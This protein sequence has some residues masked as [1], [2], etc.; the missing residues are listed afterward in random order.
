[1]DT[2]L[3][4]LFVLGYVADL[5]AKTCVAGLDARWFCRGYTTPLAM[6]GVALDRC[7]PGCNSMLENET[8]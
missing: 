5:D 3:W 2:R 6:R 1:M 4:V 8:M 7:L